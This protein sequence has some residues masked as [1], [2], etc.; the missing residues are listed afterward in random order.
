[1]AIIKIGP[2]HQVTIPK[3]AFQQ[4]YLEAGDV[5]EAHVE[6]KK[7]VLVPKR[8]TE[9]APAV[10]LSPDEQRALASARKKIFK[11]RKDLL[12]SR[13][14][15]L[16]EA[17]AAAKVGLIDPDQIYWWLEEWQKHEREAEAEE[18]AGKTIGP[19]TTADELFRSLEQGPRRMRRKSA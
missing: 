7:L 19:F 11:I 13:G 6:G 18:R 14:L 1:M 15:T 4:L 17:K 3:D 2:K 8:L 12:H 5:L 16:R 9:K 10:K